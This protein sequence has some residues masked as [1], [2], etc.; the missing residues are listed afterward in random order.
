MAVHK[1]ENQICI[2]TEAGELI[3]CRV[4]TESHR[5]AEVLGHRPHA[6]ILLAA[7]KLTGTIGPLLPGL[8]DDATLQPLDFLGREAHRIP[9]GLPDFKS[10]VRL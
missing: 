1:R 3:E 2:L 4:R 5:F 10:G 6:R 7:G 8:L 9:V